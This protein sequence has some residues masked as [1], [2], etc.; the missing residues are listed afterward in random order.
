MSPAAAAAFADRV[1]A[2][3]LITGHQPQESGYA[4][5]GDRHII[6]AS[7]HNQG[8]FL[9]LSLSEP[10]DMDGIVER[11][12]KFVS[13]ALPEAG[14]TVDAAFDELPAE[15]VADEP[16][17]VFQAEQE[18]VSDAAPAPPIASVPPEPEPV[19]DPRV[20]GDGLARQAS[21]L[22][23]KQRELLCGMMRDAFVEIRDL[24]NKG[25]SGQAAELAGLFR[26]VPQAMTGWVLWN[27]HALREELRRYEMKY[28]P[29]DTS[30]SAWMDQVLSL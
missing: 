24:C 2:R 1:G 18:A 25:L 10:Y 7:D 3:I 17:S 6:I 20:N 28:Y 16:S 15:A 27:P 29:G 23:D 12:R 26:D 9:Q 4:V 13:I 8:V 11:V 19:E 14:P 30:Y 21:P 5:N 22:N